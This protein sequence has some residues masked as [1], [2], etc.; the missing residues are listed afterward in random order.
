MVE[1]ICNKL[2]SRIRK[3]MPD[4]NDERA[5][6]INYGLQLAF[7][8]IPKTF[9]I[10]GIAW[11]LKVLDL[12]ILA[13]IIIMPYR[14]VVGGVHFKTHVKCVVATSIF[15]IGTAL[16]SKYIVLEKTLQYAITIIIW[17]FSIIMISLYAPAD[18]EDVPILRKKERKLKK[19]ISY[20]IMTA[21]LVLS[22]L[23]K[24]TTISNILLFETLFQ[25]ISIT[26]PM[27]KLAKNKY[28]YEEY[29]RNNT[30]IS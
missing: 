26:R 24:N 4:I 21:M 18:T 20:V 11:L 14:A 5:E 29:M 23:I 27:Y 10:L 2:T 3:E 16:L 15:Y 17:F 1:T 30:N 19:I 25:T 9:I 28:G 12:T 6:V 13:I 7:G 8:E 22:V